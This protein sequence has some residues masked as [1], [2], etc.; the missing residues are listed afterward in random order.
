MPDAF[1]RASRC[2]SPAAE[3]YRPP[4]S[5]EGRCGQR[6]LVIVAGSDC[7]QISSQVAGPM[8]DPASIEPAIEIQPQCEIY[9]HRSPPLPRIAVGWERMAAAA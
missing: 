4:D 1:E 2:R 6:A 5:P 3:Q 7:G 9:D 8:S